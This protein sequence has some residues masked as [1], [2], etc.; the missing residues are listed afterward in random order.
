MPLL[1]KLLLT[2]SFFIASLCDL[3]TRTIPDL[4]HIL[5][6]AAGLLY[7]GTGGISFADAAIGLLVMAVVVTGLILTKN[8]MGGGDYKMML[9]LAFTF[10]L[11]DALPALVLAFGLASFAAL[12]GKATRKLKGS[13]TIPL[14]PFLSVGFLLAIISN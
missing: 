14:A 5:I 4:T 9:A 11:Y 8:P 6:A 3:R 7:M 13:D 10:G 12:T 1:A 2:I